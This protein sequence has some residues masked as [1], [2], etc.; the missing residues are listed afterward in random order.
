[1]LENGYTP[2]LVTEDNQVLSGRSI[3]KGGIKNGM[4]HNSFRTYCNFLVMDIGVKDK[5]TYET[6][7]DVWNRKGNNEFMINT[8]DFQRTREDC[9]KFANKKL[10]NDP[11]NEDGEPDHDDW[12]LEIRNQFTFKT[13][14][15]TEEVFY[16]ENGIYKPNG[17]SVIKEQCQRIIQKCRN[18][19]VTEVMGIIKRSTPCDRSLFDKDPDLVNCKNCI[20]N[21][22]TGE[23][24]DHTPDLLFRTQIPVTYDPGVLPIE[25][26]RFLRECHLDN[27]TYYKVLEEAA[28]ILLKDPVFQV[29]F[30][31]TGE[32]SNGKSVWLKWL[33]R[34]FGEENCTNISIHELARNRF[35]IAE[36]DSKLLNIY[37]DIRNDA[38][39][40]NDLIKTIIAGDTL[41]VERKNKHPFKI[42]PYAKLFF[43]ANKIPEISDDS[44]AMY[45]RF[46]ITP[47][48]VVFDETKRDVKKL[49]K[50]STE[51]EMSGMLNLFMKVLKRLQNRGRF[52]YDESIANRKKAW[53]HRADQVTVFINEFVVKQDGFEIFADELYAKYMDYTNESGKV[54]EKQFSDKI[55]RSMGVT[56]RK[57]RRDGE[58][59]YK[60]INLTLRENLKAKEQT[61]L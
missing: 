6:L 55:I 32:G 45:R 11:T 36:L 46:S 20:L 23:I 9:W 5:H 33:E 8:A 37:A 40:D 41:T 47:W 56:K 4:L 28:Y 7:T 48:D 54:T 26:P 18:Y 31:H 27:K 1:M 30:M 35:K 21:V 49:D 24:I 3:A 44:I 22:K 17:E 52:A 50:M 43:S 29:A 19:D 61:T 16:Y 39:E 42:N 13:M 51:Q 2:A 38:L 34:F 10:G 53:V 58:P 59:V 57:T 25:V 60:W 15:D 12:A 14:R